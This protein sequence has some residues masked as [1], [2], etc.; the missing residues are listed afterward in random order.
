MARLFLPGLRCCAAGAGFVVRVNGC[1]V[2]RWPFGREGK[3]KERKQLAFEEGTW[4][5]GRLNY[6]GAFCCLC[7]SILY[8]TTLS[9]TRPISEPCCCSS[10][11]S[12]PTCVLPS[13]LFPP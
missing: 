9:H 6:A 8:S 4:V 13:P 2:M 12:F 10:R 3:Q 7:S 1:V 11:C 5:L